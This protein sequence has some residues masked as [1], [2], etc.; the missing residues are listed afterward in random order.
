[1]YFP[2]VGLVNLRESRLRSGVTV[3]K[4]IVVNLEAIQALLD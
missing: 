1:M 4:D 2:E 3:P